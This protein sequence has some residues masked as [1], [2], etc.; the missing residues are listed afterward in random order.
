[1]LIGLWKTRPQFTEP[2][3]MTLGR[4]LDGA[5]G[6]HPFI[7]FFGVR[8]MIWIALLGLVLAFTTYRLGGYAMMVAIYT[9]IG[10]VG[11]IVIAL[12]IIVWLAQRFIRGRR[13]RLPQIP[14]L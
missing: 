10:Q 13:G 8:I 7:I 6:G 3:I 2:F 11:I 14:R 5:A 4:A 9:V 12:G 1:M